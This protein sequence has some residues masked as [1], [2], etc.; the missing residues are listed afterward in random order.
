MVTFNDLT[1]GQKNAFETALK[2]IDQKKHMTIRGPAGTGKTTLMKFLLNELDR[3]GYNGVILTAPTH[4]AKK[5]LS[6]A[7]GRL[8]NTIHSVF[9]INPVT[10]EENCIFEQRQLPDLS[11][12]RVIVV[13]ECSM[14]DRKLF[15]IIMNTIPSWCVII[16][17]GDHAQLRPVDLNGNGA[18]LL[19][20]FFTDPRFLQVELTE[21]RR[22]GENS[23]II[24]VGTDIRN[25]KWIYPCVRDG[26]GVHQHMQVADFMK[27]YFNVVKKP[28]DFHTSRCLAYTN[29]TVDKLNTI[30]R[31][32]IFKTDFPFV[33]GEIL[34]MQEPLMQELSYQ[35]KKM[36]EIIFN[37]GQ[38]VRI[39]QIKQGTKT[40][41]ARGMDDEVD[42]EYF[43]LEVESTEEEE[44]EYAKTWIDVIVSDHEINKFNYYQARTAQAYK[45]G[46]VKAWWKDFWSNKNEFVKIKPLPAQTIHKSQGSTFDNGFMFTGC[47]HSADIDLAQQL[48]YVGTT[49]A[50]HDVHYI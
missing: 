29:K 7:A 16:A 19:S 4:Q 38:H 40:I 44:D 31:K 41:R 49:R 5:E 50:R 8:A 3:R 46:E 42:I 28:E 25:G 12:A 17:V 15:D 11:K 33:L 6:K 45:S 37:N 22:Q 23:P 30:I 21:I 36:Q 43:R 14:P 26:H 34:V 27:A 24:Q 13:D 1:D 20:P 2:R 9:K 48:L 47:I 39:L 18:G 10:L 35:G 32:H